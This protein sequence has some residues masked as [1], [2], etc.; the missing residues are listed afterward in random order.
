MAIIHCI[1]IFTVDST[2]TYYFVRIFLAAMK[3]CSL[4]FYV[5][6]LF[7]GGT[8]RRQ[9]VG[10]LLCFNF[11]IKN[12]TV[13]HIL[14]QYDSFYKICLCKMIFLNFVT[15]FQNISFVI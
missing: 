6:G 13:L 12:F 2:S 10:L 15:Y 1:A 11:S 9:H 5:F 14:G 7:V 3:I 8:V 4:F